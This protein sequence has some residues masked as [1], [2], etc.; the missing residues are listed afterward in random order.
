MA[1][2]RASSRSMPRARDSCGAGDTGQRQRAEAAVGRADAA[3][4]SG[5]SLASCCGCCAPAGLAVQGFVDRAAL[6]AAW[7]PDITS[8][9]RAVR[10][11]AAVLH[12]PS[13]TRDGATAP[14][15]AV[16]CRCRRASRRVHDAWLRLAAATLVQ[17]TRF[18]P[19]HDRASRSQRCARCCRSWPV[20]AQRDGAGPRADVDTGSGI[21][22]LTLTRDQFAAASRDGAGAARRGA[23]GAVR[24]AWRCVLLVADV[25]CC[26]CP[27]STPHLQARVS[28]ACV[29][30]A[31]GPRRAAP[32]ACCAPSA[33]R[34]DGGVPYR[35][36]LPLIAVP[37]SDGSCCSHWQCDASTPH[38]MATHLIY[39]GR[40]LPI[41]ADGLVLGRDPGDDSRAAIA[42][43]HRRPVA[44]PLHRC[45]A[46]AAARR[47]SITPASAASSMARACA[48]ARLLRGGQRAAPGRPRH[49]TAAGRAD[50]HAVTDEHAPH[51]AVEVF[52]LLLPRLHLL[53]L[54]RR[55][56]VLY[57]RLP[58]RPASSASTTT[59]SCRPRS[60]GSRKKC[61]IGTRNLVVLRNT[62]EKTD[63]RH[64]RRAA[65][66]TRELHRRNQPRRA[67]KRCASAPPAWRSASTST[68]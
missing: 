22:P 41:P 68:S 47:S 40:A 15:C 45:A 5:R 32:R 57:H 65:A 11:R 27:A 17:Q 10:S 46:T 2:V 54:R 66:R 37:A 42:R 6:L 43:R 8:C 1:S 26:S 25:D 53:R 13:R 4:G 55:G 30:G 38:V 50:R 36:R 18:D 51:A 62:L 64:Q 19:L 56:A 67:R 7:L 23:A 21:V 60:T 9:A 44:P 34:S 52:S 14:R 3:G 35:T 58:A 16:T 31:D 20:A 63:H 48:A 28:H 61:S 33:P 39:R 29:R 12:Q 24:R 49:R 59:T